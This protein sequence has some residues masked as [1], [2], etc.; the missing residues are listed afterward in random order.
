MKGNW[1]QSSTFNFHV[2]FSETGERGQPSIL[3]LDFVIYSDILATCRTKRL[4]VSWWIVCRLA[5][6]GLVAIR[7]PN[8]LETVTSQ[9]CRKKGKKMGTKLYVGNLS[10]DSTESDLKELFGQAGTVVSCDL[11]M[12]RDTG[13]SRGFA[14]VE[15]SSEEEAKKA[16]ADCNGKDVDGRTLKVNEA[17][18]REDRPS[19][20]S[21]G[22]YR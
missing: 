16:I 22:G 1:G 21:G 5:H 12:D 2:G 11:I 14:F 8:S 15:M 17:K 19:R 18:P 7:N 10:F 3:L 13:K 6:W 9:S 20:D 4:I